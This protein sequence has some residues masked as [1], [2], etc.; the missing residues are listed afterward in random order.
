MDI[1]ALQGPLGEQPMAPSLPP[2]P[3]TPPHVLAKCLSG[4][5]M[6]RKKYKE[7]TQGEKGLKMTHST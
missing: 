7:A 6:S 2:F 4:V 3:V 5:L 1:P